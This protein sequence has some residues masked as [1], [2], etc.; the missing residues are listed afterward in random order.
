MAAHASLVEEHKAAR[1]QAVKVR[2]LERNIHALQSQIQE[3]ES[4]HTA[5]L[6][7]TTNS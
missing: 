1:E 2:G 3:Q 5:A 6:K 7:K 4:A